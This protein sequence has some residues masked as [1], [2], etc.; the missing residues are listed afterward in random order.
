MRVLVLENEPI[1]A[2]EIADLATLCGH[3]VEACVSTADEAIRIGLATKPDLLIADLDLGGEKDGCDAAVILHEMI[4]LKAVFV[5]GQSD[6]RSRDRTQHAWPLGFVRK[7]FTPE[8][9]FALMRTAEGTIEYRRQM[10]HLYRPRNPV[11]GLA[12]NGFAQPHPCYP[13]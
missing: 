4:G 6:P 12:L 5:T 1:V 8:A 13:G 10:P 2:N 7:P 11:S 3:T 9:F